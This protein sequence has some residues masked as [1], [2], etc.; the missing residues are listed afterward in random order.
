MPGQVGNAVIAG[1]RTT[2]GAPFYHLDRLAPGDLITI[3]TLIG[4]HEFRVTDIRVVAPSDTWV[5]T[6]WNDGAW[7]TLTTCHP[8]FSSRQRLVVFAQLVDG[9]NAGIIHERFGLPTAVPGT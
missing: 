9:P 5:A 8:R 1:H 7:L 4:V 6:Q 3:E 2:N